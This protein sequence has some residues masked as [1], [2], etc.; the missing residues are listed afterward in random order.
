MPDFSLRGYRRYLRR[1]EKRAASAVVM[2]ECDDQLLIVKATYKPH[3]SLPGGIVDAHET[4]RQAAVRETLE[5]V[6]LELDPSALEFVL[7]VDRISE[8]AHTY[9]FVF[10]ASVT[11][12][13][14]DTIHLQASE[15]SDYAMV[16]RADVASGDR[17]YGKVI[18][19]WAHGTTGYVEQTFDMHGQA[20]D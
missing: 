17:H 20:K 11:R 3:W 9:Q 1:L 10:R 7:V 16:T 13:M 8:V 12:D 15:I 6:G 19:H 2:C 5:E 18:S 14:L 4:P